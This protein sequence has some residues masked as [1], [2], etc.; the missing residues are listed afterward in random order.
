MDNNQPIFLCIS[1]QIT[2]IQIN[3]QSDD[4]NGNNSC[5]LQMAQGYTITG[6][7]FDQVYHSTRWGPCFSNSLIIHRGQFLKFNNFSFRCQ[8]PLLLLLLFKTAHLQRAD[9]RTFATSLINTWLLWPRRVGQ[10][11]ASLYFTCPLLGQQ[12]CPVS[13]LQCPF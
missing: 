2:I 12:Q 6:Q 13:G 1:I 7:F 4:C 9:L 11:D 8:G 5:L 10:S 3:I